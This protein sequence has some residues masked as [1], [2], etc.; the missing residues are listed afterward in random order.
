M[1]VTYIAME[2]LT[3]PHTLTATLSCMIGVARSLVSAGNHYPEGRAHVLPLLMGALPGVTFQFIATF[4]ALVPLVDCSSAP[5]QRSDLTEMEKELCFASA[6]FED[7]VL[8]F[9]DRFSLL[10]RLMVMPCVTASVLEQSEYNARYTSPAAH[11]VALRKL[12]QFATSN[13]FETCVSGRMDW[14]RAGDVRSLGVTW[15][16]PSGEEEDLVFHLLSRLLG[17]ELR[18]IGEHVSG[19]RPMSREALLQSLAIVQHC[20][21]GAGSM[22]PPLDGPHVPDLV[23]SMVD[24]YEIKLYIGVVYGEHRTTLLGNKQHIRGLLIDRVLLQHEAVGYGLQRPVF[25]VHQ[26]H[27]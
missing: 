3:E 26:D 25:N 17:P 27:H 9:L 5:S 19:D 22:L 8:Q 4:T 1:S 24:L 11:A 15:H 21:L 14:G 10:C 6:Q 23:P 2:T 16:V 18:R 7:F 20:L 13:T 12:H